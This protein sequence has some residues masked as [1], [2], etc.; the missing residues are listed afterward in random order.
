MIC[1]KKLRFSSHPRAKVGNR[2]PPG[3]ATAQPCDAGTNTFRRRWGVRHRCDN[4]ILPLS[5][6]WG[7]WPQI[8]P[9]TAVFLNAERD[10]FFWIGTIFQSQGWG[11]WPKNS[12]KF[13]CHTF[14]LNPPPPAPLSLS[15]DWHLHNDNI[16]LIIFCIS[17]IYQP[18]PVLSKNVSSSL[19]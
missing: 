1:M 7:F 16:F 19:S 6:S 2:R 4:W 10:M 14:A 12:K 3:S 11:I 9:Q 18:D 8:L 5:Q 13:K 17:W 15:K